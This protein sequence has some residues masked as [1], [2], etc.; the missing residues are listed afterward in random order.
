VYIRLPEPLTYASWTRWA[1][2]LTTRR[3]STALRAAVCVPSIQA[4]ADALTM[5]K[6]QQPA[7]QADAAAF[8]S[9]AFAARFRV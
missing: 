4:A 9:V 5:V 1:C 3:D 2:C 6:A 7:E 8:D